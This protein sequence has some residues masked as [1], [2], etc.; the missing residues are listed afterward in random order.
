MG[1]G[2]VWGV[3]DVQRLLLFVARNLMATV[4][5]GP[6]SVSACWRRPHCYHDRRPLTTG[7]DPAPPRRLLGGR[8]AAAAAHHARA[9]GG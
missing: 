3:G 7:A 4:C 9:L 6:R 5:P 1:E 2:S 8:L